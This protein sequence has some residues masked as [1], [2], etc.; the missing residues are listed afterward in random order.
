[1]L[2]VLRRWT[3]QLSRGRWQAACHLAGQQGQAQQWTS[4]LN[5]AENAGDLYKVA[6]FGTPMVSKGWPHACT[7]Q[8]DVHC[9]RLAIELGSLR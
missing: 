9:C 6:F 8:P 1:M 3:A 4:A 2:L 5:G 7:S